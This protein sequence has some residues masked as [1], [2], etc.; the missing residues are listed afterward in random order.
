MWFSLAGIVIS[1]GLGIHTDN[2][3]FLV[4]TLYSIA[5]GNITAED[6]QSQERKEILKELDEEESKDEEQ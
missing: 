1:I 6:E 4:W 5:L 2:P 3:W